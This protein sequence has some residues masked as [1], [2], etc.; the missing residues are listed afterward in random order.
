MV[1]FWSFLFFCFFF[2]FNGIMG[3]MMNALQNE[4]KIKVNRSTAINSKIV[5]CCIS[6]A[7]VH[8]VLRKFFFSLIKKRNKSM[9]SMQNCCKPN[10]W[11]NV[12]AKKVLYNYTFI[13]WSIFF[14]RWNVCNVFFW[15]VYLK[16][17]KKR[18]MDWN[19]CTPSHSSSDEHIFIN[20]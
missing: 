18:N 10:N 8:K 19:H 11:F 9:E 3:R 2:S 17:K 14:Y 20:C 12:N 5:K 1:N 15:L 16:G 13:F 6:T 4:H 7:H